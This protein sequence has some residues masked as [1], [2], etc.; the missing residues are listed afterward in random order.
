MTYTGKIYG[1]IGRKFIELKPT[2]EEVDAAMAD[3]RRMDWLADPENPIGNVQLPVGAV[4]EN[5]H[6]LRAA[7]DAAMSGTYE[8]N[9]PIVEDN[10]PRT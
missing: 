6:C 8:K 4:T 2:T 9:A 10:R 5:A 3:K 7:I 1:K